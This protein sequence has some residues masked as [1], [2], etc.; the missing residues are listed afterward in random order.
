MKSFIYRLLSTLILAKFLSPCVYAEFT[1]EIF[2]YGDVKN[3]KDLH[4]SLEGITSAG[5]K[6]IA[7]E[8]QKEDVPFYQKL[9]ADKEGMQYFGER[10][11]R[12]PAD[13]E[14]RVLESWIPRF[15]NGNPHG[16]LT[17][18]DLAS[19]KMVGYCVAGAG[20]GP[21]ASEVAF[22]YSKDFWN[23]GFGY[24]VC[25]TILKQWG[26][27]VRRIGLGEGLDKEADK[28]I[29]DAFRCFGGVELLRLDATSSIPNFASVKII[30]KVGFQPAVS[31]VKNLEPVFDFFKTE[32]KA[33]KFCEQEVLKSFAEKNLEK[34]VRYRLIDPEGKA[35][36]FSHHKKYNNIKYHFEY[37]LN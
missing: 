17:I 12:P 13:T 25:H 4:V 6:W 28:V 11:V 30:D 22:A 20:D 34:G 21:G 36:T 5:A 26:P 35:R 23:Q 33:L 8:V 18:I 24:S 3:A 16:A 27:E 15:Q 19:K 1:S 14:K 9:F 7:R 31:A 37:N 2:K 29:I 10:Q 32:V